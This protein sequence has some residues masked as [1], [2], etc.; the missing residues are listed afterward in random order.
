MALRPD[1]PD[2]HYSLGIVLM[3]RTNVVQAEQA[4][5][6]ALRLAPGHY[7]ARNNASLCALRLGRLEDAAAQFQEALRLHPGDAIAQANLDLVLK[8]RR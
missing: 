4:F 5:L 7:K 3:N 1:L 8:M 2:A 6:A